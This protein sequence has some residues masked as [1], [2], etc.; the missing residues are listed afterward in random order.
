LTDLRDE[1]FT[2]LG[3]TDEILAEKMDQHAALQALVNRGINRSEARI[4]A[5]LGDAVAPEEQRCGGRGSGGFGHFSL[6]PSRQLRIDRGR[7]AYDD[8][9]MPVIH[10]LPALPG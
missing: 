4:A 10:A 1:T 2:G 6:P 3:L 8:Y 7:A 9:S 5:M